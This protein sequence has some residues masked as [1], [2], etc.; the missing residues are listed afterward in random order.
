MKTPTETKQTT[1]SSVLR[2]LPACEFTIRRMMETDQT[3]L[4]QCEELAM[5]EA[6]LSNVDQLPL[7]IRSE[8]RA[9]WQEIVDRLAK[10]IDDALQAKRNPT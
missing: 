1:L 3:F 2:R 4:D 9:E 10:E 6:A 7:T 8:R 5:A